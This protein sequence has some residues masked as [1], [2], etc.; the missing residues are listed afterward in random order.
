MKK[1]VI[2]P[3]LISAM[4]AGWAASPQIV[5]AQSINI[6]CSAE[7][8]QQLRLRL[9]IRRMRLLPPKGPKCLPVVNANS[10]DTTFNIVIEPRPKA[11]PEYL[12]PDGSVRVATS[13]D[14]AIKPA[15]G[16]TF[17]GSN[18]GNLI[19]V[20]V[21]GDASSNPISYFDIIADGIGT[22]DPRVRVVEE[23]AYRGHLAAVLANLREFLDMF[24][25]V[26][27]EY[28]GL[29]EETADSDEFI[30]RVYGLAPEDVDQLI[31]E[32]G[33]TE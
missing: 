19:E 14:S 16:L 1:R 29:D 27:S 17:S 21:T 3:I 31:R 25:I 9:G 18:I 12:Y 13:P 30:R 2:V 10:V 32:Y 22:L 8:M 33:L 26:A 11:N 20:T 5:H 7:Q 4:F 23:G 6:L 24:A 28:E 15:G